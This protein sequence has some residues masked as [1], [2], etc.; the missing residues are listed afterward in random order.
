MMKSFHKL[1]IILLLIPTLTFGIGKTNK[2]RHEK[3]KKI[4][5]SFTVNNDATLSIDNKY[6]DINITTWA[7]NSIEIDVEITIKG[8]D[9]GDV[10]DQLEKIDIEFNDSPNLVEAKTI[11]K[12]NKSSWSWWGKSKKISYKIIYTVKM[13]ISNNVKLANDY[14]AISLSELNGEASINCDYGKISIGDLRGNN[15]DI[16]LDYCST[17]TI[18][19][20][21]D[22]NINIDYSKLTIESATD[23]KLN[24]DYSSFKLAKATNLDFNIDYGSLVVNEITNA[25]G[26]GDYTALKFGTVKKNLKVKSDYGSIKIENLAN[27]FESVTIDSEYAGIKIGTS[28][29]NNFSFIIDLQYAGFK[30]NNDNVELL[31]SIVKNSK[32][33]YEGIYGKGN[34]NSK[35]IIKSEYGSVTFSEN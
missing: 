7:K 16:N 11:F 4:A 27:G 2:K 19:S 22:G 17:S 29:T 20:M 26:N 8:D 3:S 35:I 28:A 31:K 14:G 15:T 6:G 5:K 24:A 33:Y 23:L 1:T 21:K 32:K 25:T 9:V 12:K 13:P 10:E 30:R 34:S 18:N